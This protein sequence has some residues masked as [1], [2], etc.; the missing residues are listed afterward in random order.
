MQRLECVLCTYCQR[1]CRTN[2]DD[3]LVQTDTRQRTDQ[4]NY[5]VSA[6]FVSS[7]HQTFY[8]CKQNQSN[9][10]HAF[11]SMQWLIVYLIVYLAVVHV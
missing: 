8:R 6:F 7:R 4:I 5:S 3:K 11:K 1:Y 2:R 9:D 10:Y